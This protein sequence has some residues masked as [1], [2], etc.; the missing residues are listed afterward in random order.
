MRGPGDIQIRISPDGRVYMD[1]LSEELL[2]VVAEVCPNDPSFARRLE[3]L[4]RT[5]ARRGPQ[6]ELK[7]ETHGHAA[8]GQ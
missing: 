7:E 1:G 8:S 6:E 3:V 5:R 2:E 4:R